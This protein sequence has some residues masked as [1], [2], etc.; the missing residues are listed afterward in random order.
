IFVK[1]GF[2]YGEMKQYAASAEHYE[3]AVRLGARDQTLYYNLAYTYT[4]LGREKEAVGYYEKISPA[5]KK[6]LSIIAHYY[7]KE[8]KYAKA[9]QYYQRILK[10]EP[11]KASSYASLGY[12]WLSS[13]NA[14][15]AIEY[16]LK[17]LKYDREDDEIYANLGAAYEKKGLYPEALK[18]YRDAYE[19][20][21][22]TKA[23]S[24]I[25]RLRIQL[26]H[27]KEKDGSES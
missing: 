27:K 9:I 6:T 13:G 1:M 25:P 20:N 18:A 16:Y 15:K 24:R 8:K 7:L 19:I 17:A 22:E 5:N 3:K 14:D 11:K 23:A 26:L 21:P 4:K 12:A 10:L 2:A